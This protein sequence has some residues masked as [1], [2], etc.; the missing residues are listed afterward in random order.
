MLR[1]LSFA[2][3]LL[4]GLGA[5]FAWSPWQARAQA[6]TPM[7]WIWFDEGNPLA[8]APAETRYFRRVFDLKRPTNKSITSATLEITADNR[9]VVSVN[10]TKVGEGDNWASLSRFNV[11]EHLVNG[12]NV[13]SVAATN[14]GG[15]AGLV[16]RLRYKAGK[17]SASIVSDS[18]W[19][20]SKM[21]AKGWEKV[22]FDDGKWSKVRVLGAYG[23]VGPWTGGGG[24]GVRGGPPRFSPAQGFKVELAVKDPEDRGPF[25]LV[26][27]TID[28][29]GRLLLS[30]EGGPILVC[31]KPDKSG[32]M[33][34]VK[35]YCTLVKNCHG[36]RWVKDAL[37]LVGEG[38]KGTGLYRCRDTKGGDKIDEVTLLHRTNGGMGEHGPH[39]VING[40][41][42]LPLLRHRQ[43]RH[44]EHRPEEN[45]QP[46]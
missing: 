27:M 32:V 19:K 18:A 1:R 45:T 8:D 41:G 29:K 42:W 44:H 2:L 6:P 17:R 3:F 22:D 31:G 11:L 43:P 15:P 9:F 35:E 7:Q 25:S 33:Q 38:P 28:A 12:K 30:Q 20:V 5:L 46:R 24:G 10:G 40:P 26:N 21:S 34:E 37:Y 39:A 23:K 14:E 13:I 36:M 4:L 16:V